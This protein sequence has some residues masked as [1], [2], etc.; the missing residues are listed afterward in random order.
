MSAVLVLIGIQMAISVARNS[1]FQWDVVG[2]YMFSRPILTGLARTLELTAIS[3][4]VGYALGAL[5][6]VM[7]LSGA[8]L[9]AAV[10]RAFVWFFRGTPLLVQLLFWFNLGALYR[11]I[12]VGVPFGGPTFFSVDSNSVITP[13]TA[14]ILG[15]GLNAGAYFSE[16]VRA[17]ILSIHHG[18]VEAASALGLSRTQTLRTVIMPQAMRVIIPPGFNEIIG[19]LKYS[20]MV[21]VL[22]VPEL[23]YT[24]ELIY[25]RTFQTIPML[26]VASIWYLILTTILSIVQHYIEKHFGKGFR[27]PKVSDRAGDRATAYQLE[28]PPEGER[29]LGG[30]SGGNR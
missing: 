12:S 19:M 27:N 9:P 20:S 10:S 26:I 30:E 21:S 13:F 28:G 1:N 29:M 16:V 22:A 18:Q 14:A 24:A 5:L 2:D 17:G 11:S 3:A 23:L 6:A 4:V 7:N 15:L 8:Y 25:A